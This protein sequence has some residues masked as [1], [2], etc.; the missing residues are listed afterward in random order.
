MTRPKITKDI[1]EKFVSELIDAAFHFPDSCIR[2]WVRECQAGDF[3]NWPAFFR[4]VADAL[5]EK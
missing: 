2:D 1:A 5:E 3:I 4:E